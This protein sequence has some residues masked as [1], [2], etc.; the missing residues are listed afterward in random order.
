MNNIDQ[1][2]TDVVSA[3]LDNSDLLDAFADTLI[4]EEIKEDSLASI[5][6]S[7]GRIQK[8]KFYLWKKAKEVMNMLSNKIQVLA[9]LTEYNLKN[10]E[11]KIALIKKD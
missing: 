4:I 9:V 6:A 8:L 7:L 1:E 10:E 5:S 3:I 11:K 2:K